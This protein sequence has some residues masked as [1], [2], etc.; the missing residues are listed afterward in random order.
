MSSIALSTQK[1]PCI[2]LNEEGDVMSVSGKVFD[3]KKFAPG[4]KRCLHNVERELKELRMGQDIPIRI[5]KVVID[6]LTNTTLGY[7]FLTNN[8]FTDKDDDDLFQRFA[9]DPECPLFS[10]ASGEA[11]LLPTRVTD[12]LIKAR[13]A[14]KH[15]LALI[16]VCCGL[17]PRGSE[18]VDL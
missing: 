12:W 14:M 9:L 2:T 17:P 11:V 6:D 4:I 3:L 7:S 15:L 1:L 5:P 18:A 16:H 10:W 8:K 13:V